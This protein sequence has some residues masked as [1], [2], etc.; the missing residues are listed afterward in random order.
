MMIDSQAFL[1]YLTAKG[2]NTFF[3]V[4]DSL[5]EPLNNAIATN[6]D[7]RGHVI[8]A[9]EGAAVGCAV[10]HFLGSGDL[11]GVYLQNSG[12]GNTVNPL[13][14]I[15][16]PSVYGVPM[17]MIIGWRGEPGMKDEPQHM[18]QGE[19]TLQLLDDLGVVTRSV[20]REDHADWRE[21]VGSLIDSA[22]SERRAVA[23]VIGKDTLQGFQKSNNRNSSPN[24]LLRE[25]ALGIVM[26]NLPPED[27]TVGTTGML[28]RELYEFRNSHEANVQDF[29]NVGGMGHTSSVA[30]GLSLAQP[31]KRIW[32]L[33]GDGSAIMHLGSVAVIAGERPK[34]LKYIVFNNRAHDSVGG[35]PTAAESFSFAPVATALGYDLGVTASTEGEI[36]DGVEKLQNCSGPALLEINIRT[37]SRKNLGRPK[38]SPGELIDRMMITLGVSRFN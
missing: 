8:C 1:Q 19:L 26:S 28:G 38:E 25:S 2:I 15:A 33:D 31:R 10:G 6:E 3:G 12:L 17:F 37:G 18:R 32:C 30:L 13:L 27:L 23:L 9:N 24:L 22:R 29:L 14:S 36:E 4:P 7:I 5:L 35:Q 20:T 11:A 34:N 16:D 21:K